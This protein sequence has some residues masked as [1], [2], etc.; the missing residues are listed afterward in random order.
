MDSL[1]HNVGSSFNLEK[2][3]IARKLTIQA[4]KEIS[5][6]SFIGMSEIDGNKIINEVLEEMGA[7]KKWHP[8][9]FRIGKNTTKSFREE[10]DESVVLLEDDLFFIDIGPVWDG[11]EGDYGE[12]FTVG[13]HDEYAKACLACKDVFE[14]TAHEW[15]NK[16]LTGIKLY[17]FA[18][19]YAE[20]LGYTLN[21]AMKGHRLGDFP[22]H[23]FY[24]GGMLETEDTPCDNLW[25][26]EIHL[27]SKDKTFGSFFEDVLRK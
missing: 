5:N 16:N 24:K 25:V 9:K 14:K 19:E 23:L 21:K 26:L 18:N 15:R 2:F 1:I 17:K 7:Q 12:T 10:S 3:L 13:S 4:V 11:H 6:R 8:N 27:I 20:S 22:H